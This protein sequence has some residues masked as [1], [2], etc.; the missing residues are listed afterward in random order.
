[1][2]IAAGGDTTLTTTVDLSCSGARIAYDPGEE[3]L[4]QG[5][6]RMSFCCDDQSVHLLGLPVWHGPGVYGVRFLVMTDVDRLCVAEL[7]DHLPTSG[8]GRAA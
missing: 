4:P 6:L 3:T 1:V 2:F 5:P 7:L 8:A